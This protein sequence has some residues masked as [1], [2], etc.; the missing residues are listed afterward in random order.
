MCTAI[1]E[2]P[3]V[4]ALDN[5]VQD[6]ARGIAH[7]CE[8]DGWRAGKRRCGGGDARSIVKCVLRLTALL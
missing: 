8:V 3:T 2:L 6:S 4:G 5:V 7:G 1:I